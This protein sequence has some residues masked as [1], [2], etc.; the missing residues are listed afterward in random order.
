MLPFSCSI[1]IGI[2]VSAQNASW[3]TY[4]VRYEALTQPVPPLGFWISTHVALS[5]LTVDPV[6]ITL[7]AFAA[8][9]PI[10]GWL[11]PA[12]ERM[13]NTSL[14]ATRTTA[15]GPIKGAGAGGA[16]PPTAMRT[17]FQYR[18]PSGRRV[19]YRIA[20]LLPSNPQPETNIACEFE[21][22]RF[23]IEYGFKP[24]NKAFKSLLGSETRTVDA[25]M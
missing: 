9:D 6:L 21:G 5:A 11:A 22:S 12:A 14:G 7:V 4:S 3:V 15:Y 24:P 8:N 17:L 19:T 18:L 16:K 20:S 13:L 10:T 2:R 23:M 25:A 1:R